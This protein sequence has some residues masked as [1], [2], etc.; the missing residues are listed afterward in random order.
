MSQAGLGAPSSRRRFVKI[1]YWEEK[2]WP[3]PGAGTGEGTA[4]TSPLF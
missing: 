1:R 3:E 4:N 2:V